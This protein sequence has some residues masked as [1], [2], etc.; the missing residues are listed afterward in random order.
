[1]DGWF[2]NK[3]GDELG[4]CCDFVF[5]FWG[6]RDN[7]VGIWGVSSSFASEFELRVWDFVFVW[8]S[9]KRS[10]LALVLGSFFVKDAKSVSS[11]CQP[12]K[13]KV[14]FL[15]VGTPPLQMLEVKVNWDQ[16]CWIVW[17]SNVVPGSKGSIFTP[18]CFLKVS[19]GD[20]VFSPSVQV[21][22]GS[23]SQDK[24]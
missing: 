9:V 17:V 22:K 21:F 23:S 8:G 1:M 18:I 14:V 19:L 10:P 16:D 5:F 12:F 24:V 13:H 2:A 7:D 15:G 3:G 4:D 11:G 6:L 20:V